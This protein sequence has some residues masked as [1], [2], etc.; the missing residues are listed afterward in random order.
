MELNMIQRDKT[1]PKM[2][3]NFQLPPNVATLSANFSIK[4]TVVDD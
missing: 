4:G 3:M 2:I 1:M